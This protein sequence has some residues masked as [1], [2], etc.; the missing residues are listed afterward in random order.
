MTLCMA[1][2]IYIV[3]VSLCSFLQSVRRHQLLQSFFAIQRTEKTVKCIKTTEYLC[4]ICYKEISSCYVHHQATGHIRQSMTR[5]DI[6]IVIWSCH[7]KT[8][9][10]LCY[11]SLYYFPPLALNKV[12]TFIKMLI[13]GS[14]GITDGHSVVGKHESDGHQLLHL[15]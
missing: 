2:I 3:Y 1:T 12:L 9:V 10:T 7:N 5:S 4:N 14:C 8:Y 11:V 15:R 13:S 6:V